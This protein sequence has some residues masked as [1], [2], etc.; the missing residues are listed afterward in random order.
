MIF[1]LVGVGFSVTGRQTARRL[2]I[3]ALST[4]AL[5]HGGCVATSG[6]GRAQAK[7]SSPADVVIVGGRI[8]TG[9]SPVAPPKDI[10]LQA[11]A[12]AIRG[13]KILD[14]GDDAAMQRYVGH[15]TRLID[16]G[17][18]RIIPG[19]TD[20]HT[21]IVG[22]GFQ[23]ARLALRDA[24]GKEQFIGMVAAEALRLEKDE[25]VLGGRWSVESWASPQHPTKAWID[26]VT[27]GRPALLSRMDGH[28]ALVNSAAL[29]LAG[30]DRNGPP[31]PKGGEIERD[32]ATGEPT[33]ILKE[34]AMGLVQKHIPSPSPQRRYEALRRA[35][36]HAGS[37]GVTSVHDMCGLDD[38]PVFRRAEVEGAMTI[39][40]T[41]YLQVGDWSDDYGHIEAANL[42]SDLVRLA[43]FKGY[44]DGSLGSRTAYM[45]DHYSDAA[46]EMLYPR[47]QL[48]A[49]ADRQEAFRELVADA[50]AR[51]YQIAAHAIGDEANHQL[52]NAYAYARR[53]NG[54]NDRYHRDE[55]AQHLQ[56]SDIPRF[57]ELGVVAS[58]QPYHKADDGR[59]AEQAIGKARL[60]GS[61][62]YR[63]LVDS[64]A[65]LVF[66]S[67]WP[68]VT[69]NP[70]AGVDS[71]VNA[72]TLTGEVWLKSHSLTVAEALYAYTAAPA[73]AIGMGEKLGTIAPGKYADLLILDQD[74]FTI[75]ADRLG[76][77]KP[78][79][80][81]MGGVVVYER[82]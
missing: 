45:H 52:L 12:V 75:D 69:L 70:F 4:I 59:Y 81:I 6:G 22:G 17:G 49:L 57:A 67:D 10:S 82:E 72:K 36:R 50:D 63:Q 53:R 8:W 80:T 60:R 28:Q 7:S 65:L 43:G 79:M 16:A 62:A 35:M 44:M 26:P 18:R 32:P 3:F 9:E 55:H 42:D 21:H 68:V 64:G 20:S 38:V 30:I 76:D 54:K 19:I 11:T 23:L 51:G 31:D 78:V 2:G 40:V 27:G 56:V 46:P 61:Y 15:G 66:G 58:M 37:L 5:W 48:T 13:G 39:R 1:S 74:P 41:G 71:A 29:A 47:G 34:S 33:G 24:K 73:K 77:V 25:W 14:Y